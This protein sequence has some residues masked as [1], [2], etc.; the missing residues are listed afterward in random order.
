MPR[1]ART[2]EQYNRVFYERCWRAGTI[3]SMPG[4]P[5]APT[6]SLTV[7]IGSGLRPR[8]PLANTVFVDLSRA[9][10][11]KLRR[12]R[13]RAVRSTV[14]CLPFPPATLGAIH[15]YDLLE[16]LTDDAAA[17]AELAR[18]LAPGGRLVLS[19]PLH[20]D[21]WHA[22][23]RIVGHARRYEP[24]A[25]VALLE[26]QGFALD[27][28][29]PFGMRPRSRLLT[30][31]GAYFLTRWPR[32]ALRYQERFLRTKSEPVIVTR[33]DTRTFIREAAALD[34]VVTV[35]TRVGAPFTR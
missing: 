4:V 12:V 27:A 20:A 33:A 10:C 30:R 28:F 17:V 34:G 19:T 18:V 2:L 21:R 26:A 31:L 23:D 6:T 13:A 8:L 7:E 14:A 29:A 25:L 32:L 15:A 9:A 11:V 16:H 1:S 3:V 35:W 22:F 24:E 5:V